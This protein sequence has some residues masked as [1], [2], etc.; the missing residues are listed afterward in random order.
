MNQSTSCRYAHTFALTVTYDD[1][2]GLLQQVISS[3]FANGVEKVIVVDNGSV[4]AS[5]QAIRKLE[6]DCNGRVAVVVLPGNLGSATGFKAGLEYAASCSDCEYLWLLDDDNRPAEGALA[7]LFNQHGKLSQLIALDRLGLVSLRSDWEEHNKV[8]QGV[9][10]GKVY[11]RKSS[12]M[13]FHLLNPPRRFAEVFHLNR[14]IGKQPATDSPIEIPFGPYG[15]LFFHKSVLSKLGYPMERLFLYNDDTEYTSRLT[16]AGGSLFLIPSSVVHD[17][18]P[19]WHVLNKGETLFS[20]LLIADSDSRIYYATRNQ[21]YLER[22]LWTRNIITYSFNKWAFFL[23]LGL[24]ALRHRKWKRV[25][26][27]ARAV[28]QGKAGT[29]GRSEDLEHTERYH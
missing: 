28:R 25:A 1:R 19:S 18:Q 6:L 7:E 26:L 21:S 20:H 27:I 3:A 17:L 2:Y 10:V 9:P 12:F 16:K 22:Y 4:A 11:P 15:G 5:K 23:L 29:L 24:F 14:P 8:A 13:G